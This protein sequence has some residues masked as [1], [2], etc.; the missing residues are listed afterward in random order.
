MGLEGVPFPHPGWEQ[1]GGGGCLILGGDLAQIGCVP[2][3]SSHL[4]AQEAPALVLGSAVLRG[5]LGF[6]LAVVWLVIFD[7]IVLSAEQGDHP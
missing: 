1:E 5:A 7:D 4:A 6:L 3:S 2:A